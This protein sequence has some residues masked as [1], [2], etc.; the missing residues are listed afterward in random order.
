V[1]R[2]WRGRQARAARRACASGFGRPG[3]GLDFCRPRSQ[4]G[5][6]FNSLDNSDPNGARYQ[7]ASKLLVADLCLRWQ[8]TRQWSAALGIDNLSNELYWNFHPYPLRTVVAERKFD[9]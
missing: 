1:L 9:Q 5:Q 8:A 4:G 3:A 2:R 6:Q 7:G